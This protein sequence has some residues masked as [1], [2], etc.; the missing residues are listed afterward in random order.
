MCA[1]MHGSHV[2]VH[3]REKKGQNTGEG[4]LNWWHNVLEETWDWN[5]MSI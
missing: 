4:R 1:C 3:E 2:C 5:E